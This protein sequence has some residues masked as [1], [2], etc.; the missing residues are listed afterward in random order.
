VINGS[1]ECWGAGNHGQIGNNTTTN[2][3]V[4]VQVQ[5]LTSGVTATAN[6]YNHSCALVNGSV[7]CWG[8]NSYGQ[9]GG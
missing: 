7:R 9:L 8:N 3:L 2:S 1:A 5:G 6:G 4:P